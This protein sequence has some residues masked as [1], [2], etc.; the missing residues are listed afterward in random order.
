MGELFRFSFIPFRV[1]DLL[2]ILIVTIV[3]YQIYRI[4]RGTRATH[5]FAGLLLLLGAG[6]I[7]QLIGMNGMTWLIQS[8]GAVWVIAF[9]IL[10]QPELRRMLIRVGQMGVLRKFF[11]AGSDRVVIEVS[12]AAMELSRRR[13]GALIVLQRSTGLR[14]IIETGISLQ[15]EVSADLLIS[16]FFPRSPLHD[17]AVVISG[18]TV[19]AARCILPLTT[20]D[21]GDYNLGTRHLAAIGIT[22]EVDAVAVVVS[23]ETGTVSVVCNGG[24]T[25]RDL[26]LKAL[27]VELDR[28]IFP[29]RGQATII[30]SLIPK[31]NTTKK[32]IHRVRDTSSL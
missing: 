21:F 2:D 26:D 29:E 20:V 18:E 10:F 30:S 14:G 3:F 25:G 9:V 6:S 7:S 32:Q 4:I 13:F 16:T 27:S 8:V 5:M 12:K 28:L 11:R 19:V 15:A 24:F 1:I 31:K 23:E 17:G 22:E